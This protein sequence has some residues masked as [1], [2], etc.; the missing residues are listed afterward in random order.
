M[1][2]VGWPFWKWAARHVPLLIRLEVV[3]DREAGVFV[4]TSNDLRG[5]VVEM[6]DTTSAS[7]LHKEINGCVSMLM[8]DALKTAPKALPVT[9]W[10]GEALTA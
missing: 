1:Y 2:R 7:D 8:A 10:P 9:A 5:L 6:P 4:V 3:H